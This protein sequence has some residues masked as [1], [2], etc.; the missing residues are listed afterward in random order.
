MNFSFARMR[1]KYIEDNDEQDPELIKKV[2]PF[3]QRTSQ[4][5][6][7]TQVAFVIYCGIFA[8]SLLT[9]ILSAHHI[10]SPLVGA[11][12][13]WV[14]DLVLAVAGIIL[15]GAY[16]VVT[17]LYP[18]THALVEPLPVLAS[19]RWVVH[20]NRH[21]FRPL[22]QVG[23]FLVRRIF[24]LK[25]IPF[26]NEVNFTYTEDEIRCIVEESSRSGRLNALENTLIKNSFDFFD[27]MV[28][29]VMIPRNNMVVLDF[30]DDIDTMRRTISKAH[31]TCYPVCIDDKDQILGFIHV[32]D[33]MESLLHGES[34]VKKIIR[35]ILTV[36]EVMPAPSLLQLMRNRRIY[37]AVVVDEYGGTSGLV[38]LEDLVEE[39]IGEIPQ[40]VDTTPYEIVRRKDGTY[41]FD[42]TVILDDVSDR[43]EIDLDGEDGNA[44][45]GGFVFSHLER[46]PK[47]GDHVDFSGWRFS[48]LRMDGFRIMRVKAERM[49]PSA[50]AP[51]KETEK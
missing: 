19:H 51:E 3:Y 47:V 5:L 50:K 41:E 27:L 33:F 48:V 17:I 7:G 44:T 35:E 42:G 18:G 38:T 40:A 36:P 49:T 15:V 23:L 4:I 12:W 24:R 39:L 46:I 11:D 22:V 31:H 6:G 43:L 13:D 26:R 37:L 14:L 10:L 32:K 25:K 21:L 16:W 20:W 2:A 1:K 29:D 28:R 34:N 30:N 9:M 45:I 8:I